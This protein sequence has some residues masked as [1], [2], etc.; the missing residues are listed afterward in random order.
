MT[1]KYRPDR[2]LIDHGFAG[3]GCAAS[4]SGTPARPAEKGDLPLPPA[5]SARSRER[6]EQGQQ[7]KRTA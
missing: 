7:K 1:G 3:K 4:S 5:F 6:P 2:F